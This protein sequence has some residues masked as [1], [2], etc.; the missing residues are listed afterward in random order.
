LF[1]CKINFFVDISDH[2]GAKLESKEKKFRIFTKKKI[3]FIF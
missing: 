1:I 2:S 3:A